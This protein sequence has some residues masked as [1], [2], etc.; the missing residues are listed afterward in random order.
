MI[1]VLR[2]RLAAQHRW[3]VLQNMQGLSMTQDRPR[4]EG[5]V[6]H[7]LAVTHRAI[8]GHLGALDGAKV[9]KDL[10]HVGVGDVAG[11]SPHRQPGRQGAGCTAT[12]LLTPCV[13]QTSMP[14][15]CQMLQT[16]VGAARM[17]RPGLALLLAHAHVSVNLGGSRMT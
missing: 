1:R 11:E 16:G 15:A 13:Y 7:R 14:A 8:H 3:P 10:V 5:A 2:S 4:Q 9:G 6:L 12:S 17:C